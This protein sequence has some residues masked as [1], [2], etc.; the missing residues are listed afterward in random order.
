MN[1]G[2]SDV[3]M[4]AGAGTLP[5]GVTESNYAQVPYLLGGAVIGYNLGG[6]FNNLKLTAAEVADIYGTITSGPTRRSSLRTVV[7]V[8]QWDR[9]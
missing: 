7:R 5:S 4:T 9:P 2:F 8:P 6:G 1:I 3:P